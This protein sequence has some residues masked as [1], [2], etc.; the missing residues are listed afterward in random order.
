MKEMHYKEYREAL[1]T[2]GLTQ[3]GASELFQLGARTGRRYALKESRI[4]GPVAILLRLM[5]K[6]R[7]KVADIEK[8]SD[9]E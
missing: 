3:V 5:L 1:D 7:I 4:P 6:K 2:L 8:L 9:P